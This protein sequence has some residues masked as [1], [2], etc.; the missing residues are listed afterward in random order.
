MRRIDH[1]H[2]PGKKRK[3]ACIKC[4]WIRGIST[5]NRY[6]LPDVNRTLARLNIKP[7]TY[8]DFF[9]FIPKYV[10]KLNKI[11]YRKDRAGD[12]KNYYKSKEE[13]QLWLSNQ[14]KLYQKSATIIHFQD[15]G[16][17]II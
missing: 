13:A 7:L 2:G 3:Y 15:K 11:K 16:Y 12:K 10:K 5:R 6:N 4:R 14:Y 17:K 8:K 1:K 9:H